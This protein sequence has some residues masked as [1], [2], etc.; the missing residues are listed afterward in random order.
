[1]EHCA[2]FDILTSAAVR[3]NSLGRFAGTLLT[4]AV[5][6]QTEPVMLVIQVRG[7]GSVYHKW[8]NE[9]TRLL[10]QHKLMVVFS[11]L[12]SRVHSP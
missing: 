8:T 2:T 11:E 4:P 1:M 12:S 10:L 3:V 9:D 6:V 5:L 7:R